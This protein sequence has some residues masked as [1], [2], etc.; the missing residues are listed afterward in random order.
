LGQTGVLPDGGN[1]G[2][3]ILPST[4]GGVTGAAAFTGGVTGYASGHEGKIQI[5]GGTLS[6]SADNFL[7]AAPVTVDASKITLNGGTL[8]ATDSFTL[9][10]NRGITLGASGGTFSVDA[11]KSVAYAGVMAGTGGLTKSGSG[12]L[13]LT[14]ADT[15]SGGT[16]VSTGT[17]VAG[18]A[19]NAL[20]TGSVSVA[21]RL[22]FDTSAAATFANAFSVTGSGIFEN[23]GTNAIT[24][25]P[26]TKTS[27]LSLC[28]PYR[29][30]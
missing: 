11:T 15:Y 28:D 25:T 4:A 10:T 18:G 22:S 17:L 12:T 1:V 29:L 7:G 19:G 23:I 5:N 9:N 2:L 8:Q 13:T 16:T 20:G 3:A 27:F 6:V 30:Q 14:G 24:T 26:V 21:S